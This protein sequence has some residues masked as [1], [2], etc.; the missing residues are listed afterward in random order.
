MIGTPVTACGISARRAAIA[1]AKPE[2]LFM[3]SSELGWSD[4]ALPRKMLGRVAC[5]SDRKNRVLPSAALTASLLAAAEHPRA[6]RQ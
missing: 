6:V 5:G 3:V 1:P 4:L 2:S